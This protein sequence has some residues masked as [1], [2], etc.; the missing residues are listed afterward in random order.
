MKNMK[1]TLMITV[2]ALAFLTLTGMAKADENTDTITAIKAIPTN[3]ASH[4]SNEVQE[5]KEYQ[6]K[7]WAEMKAQW[8][9]LMTKLSSN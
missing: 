8:S 9:A 6:A 3:I 4:I 7:S 2:I 5:T 1:E